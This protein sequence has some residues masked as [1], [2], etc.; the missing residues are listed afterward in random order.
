MYFVALGLEAN[1]MLYGL[2]MNLRLIAEI[3]DVIG[4]RYMGVFHVLSITFP[5]DSLNIH[6]AAELDHSV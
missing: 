5:L 2:F 1:E 3:G 6:R 4:A